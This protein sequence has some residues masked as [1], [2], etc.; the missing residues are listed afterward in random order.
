MNYL[1]I[2]NVFICLKS[3]YLS[4]KNVPG[5]VEATSI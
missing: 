3:N 4:L 2:I 1:S 5:F